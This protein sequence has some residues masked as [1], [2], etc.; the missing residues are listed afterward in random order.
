MAGSLTIKLVRHGESQANTGE[1]THRDV[2]DH[3]IQLTPRGVEQARAIGRSIGKEFFEEKSLLYSSPYLRT[4]QTLKHILE[5]AG[6]ASPPLRI[7]EDPRLR[8][9]EHG[10]EDLEGQWARRQTHGWFYYRFQGGESPADCFDRTSTFLESLMRQVQ[11][12]NAEHCI[13]VSHGLTIR[14]FVMRFLHLSVE[15][16]DEMANPHNCDVITIGDKSTLDAP[17]FT[18]GSWGVS[19]L[20]RRGP[21]DP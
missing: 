10:Y 3:L 21:N 8:E 18:R 1:V 16:F 19:G 7:F 12:K 13:V 5:G 20:R 14:C 4:R 17:S 15:D 2:G 6:T 9:V 11:R